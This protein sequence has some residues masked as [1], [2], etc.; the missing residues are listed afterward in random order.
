MTA[1]ARDKSWNV[2]LVV[3]ETEVLFV[4]HVFFWFLE[5]ERPKH[6]YVHN[7]YTHTHTPFNAFTHCA[8]LLIYDVYDDMCRLTPSQHTAPK[9]PEGERVDFD[10]SYYITI[11][12][13]YTHTWISPYTQ[14]QC[15][16]VCR[17][18]TGSGWRRTCW[19]CRC[20]S[21][22]TLSR[23]REKRRI[24]LRWKREL[25]DLFLFKSFLC[26]KPFSSLNKKE[27]FYNCTAVLILFT[28]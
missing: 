28:F 18:S 19:S 16:C 27:G 26:L 24:W 5:E 11:L 25:W 3:M 21:K 1:R 13:T 20:W 23:E 9:I 22:S 12:I 15:V 8:V 14:C 10:V 7:G 2:L 17:T 4:F 6:K